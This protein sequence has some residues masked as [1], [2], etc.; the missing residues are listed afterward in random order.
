MDVR[1]LPDELSLAWSSRTTWVW[2][3]DIAQWLCAAG[4][5]WY[6]WSRG[7]TLAAFAA[8][9]VGCL[10]CQAGA[11][12]AVVWPGRAAGTRKLRDHHR[13]VTVAI[14]CLTGIF[15]IALGMPVLHKVLDEPDRPVEALFVAGS[16]L[17]LTSFAGLVAVTALSSRASKGSSEQL[18]DEPDWADLADTATVDD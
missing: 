12:A 18:P 10:L 5:V 11:V 16:T 7:A 1:D 17:L 3:G 4:A 9:L 6:M 14:Q 8:A 13:G 15:G 2:V